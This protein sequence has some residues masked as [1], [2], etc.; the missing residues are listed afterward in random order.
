MQLGFL[1]RAGA[2]SWRPE[3]VAANGKDRGCFRV[4]VARF[5]TADVQMLKKAAGIKAR[6]DRPAAEAWVKEDVEVSGP[7]AQIRQAIDERMLRNP[8]AT[9]VYDVELR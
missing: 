4:D 2:V 6:A 9:F 1:M 7:R 8:R 5:E 3:E